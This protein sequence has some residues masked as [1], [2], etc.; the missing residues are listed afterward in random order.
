MKKVVLFEHNEIAYDKLCDSLE[1]S[2]VS[3]INHATGTGKSFIALK[4]LYEHR[5]KKFLYI[6]PTYPIIEQLLDD[7]YKLGFTPEDLNLDTMIYRTLLNLDMNQ[8]YNKYDG[9]IFDEY[10]R[11]GAKETYKQIKSLKLLLQENND[12]KKFIGLTATP[13]RF[14]DRERN[15]TNEIFDGV[16]ASN[17]SLAEAMLEEL[18]PVPVYINSKIACRERLKKNS[19]K[20]NRFANSKEKNEIIQKLNNVSKKINNG[21][22]DINEMFKKYITEKNGKFIVFCDTIDSLQGYSS[23]A[24]MWFRGFGKIK[25]YEV[26]SGKK[27]KEN[28]EEINQFNNDSN[29]ISVL[30]AVDILNEGVHVKDID[31]V[32]LLR[33]TQSPIIYFQQIGRAL[34]YSGREKKIFIFDLVNNFRNHNAIDAVYREVEEE[35]KRKILESPEKK[36]KYQEILDKFKILDETREIINELDDIENEMTPEKIVL[37]RVSYAVDTLVE[38]CENNRTNLFGNPECKKAYLWLSNYAKYV[39]NEQFEKLQ[40]LDIILPNALTMTMEER[41]QM[42]EGFDSIHEMEIKQ[43]SV[44]ISKIIEFFKEEKRK[45]QPNLNDEQENILEKKYLDYLVIFDENQKDELRNIIDEN[46]IEIESFEKVILDKKINQTDVDNLIGISLGYIQNNTELPNYLKYAIEAV[47]LKYTIKSNIELFEILEKNE[48][49]IKEKKSQFEQERY[50]AMNSLVTF[51]NENRYITENE[52]KDKISQINQIKKDL[53]SGRDLGMIR[54]KLGEAKKIY[55]KSLV[56]HNEYTNIFNF[57][58][59]MKKVNLEDISQEV[60]QL[61]EN[62]KKYETLNLVIQFM[63]K[64]DGNPPDVKSENN[65]EKMLA[66]TLEDYINAGQI[67][68][69]ILD[70]QNEIGSTLYDPFKI[71]CEILLENRQELKTKMTILKNIEFFNKYGYKPLSNSPD[72]EE[73]NL[74]LQYESE[75]IKKLNDKSL[76]EL[77]RIFNSKKNLGILCAQY[78]KNKKLNDERE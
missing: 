48:D 4:Y 56:N 77:N 47:T 49:I 54:K 65:E 33:T 52:L 14:L 61:H 26:H 46:A 22:K 76:S 9:I 73:R 72:E 55:Y 21:C 68:E 57:C 43:N 28:Q 67:D 16:V 10:H 2:K 24:D 45:P 8:I 69:N 12:D 53:L 60:L 42:L 15:M 40:N 19:R 59:N 30:F 78:I 20:V 11:T 44:Y 63:I 38:E 37:S 1:K 5:D 17:I 25:K 51:I 75:C 66:Q 7:C 41:L 39:N 70:I 62:N 71:F 32:I 6:S 31:G 36:E 58:R 50:D 74:A 18:L 23:E 13:I 29:G 64:N 27:K 35:M 3:T 34:S